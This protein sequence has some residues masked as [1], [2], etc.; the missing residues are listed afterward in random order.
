MKQ[1]PSA[2]LLSPS[3]ISIIEFTF[4]VIIFLGI[5]PPGIMLP[6]ADA[7]LYL[8]FAAEIRSGTLWSLHD[9][10]AATLMRT[11]GYPFLL[12]IFGATSEASIAEASLL[13][14]VLGIFTILITM[15]S[16]KIAVRPIFV[17]LGILALFY[18]QRL[19]SHYAIT[20]WSA[21][22]FLVMLAGL[23]VRFLFSKDRRLFFI[24]T[25]ISSYLVLI[26]PALIVVLIIPVILILQVRPKFGSYILS[27]LAGLAP[28][29]LWCGFNFLRVGS[30]NL[31]TFGGISLFGVTSQLG[32]AY[33]MPDDE[34]V[35]KEFIS[36]VGQKKRPIA[37]TEAEFLNSL[38]KLYQPAL[39]NHNIYRVGLPWA[40]KNTVLL[41]ELNKMMSEYSFRV[42]EDYPWRYIKYVG[43]GLGFGVTKSVILFMGF[44]IVY[45]LSLK[46]RSEMFQLAA[47]FTLVHVLHVFL[48]SAVQVLV[49]RYFNLTYYPALFTLGLCIIVLFKERPIE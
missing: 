44:F 1:A 3:L 20:E 10:S 18:T 35:F 42:I 21:L 37:G 47:L 14:T 49:P 36:E 48:C 12:A 23:L 29:I 26:R 27:L 33:E 8:K 43:T 11:P 32:L 24:V 28:L 40:E 5:F 45:V 19:Y 13:H 46:K 39:Y 38:D 17:G 31:A 6:H 30:P 34:L 9:F 22:C 7:D 16:C 2:G 15:W 41:P 4:V 25:L